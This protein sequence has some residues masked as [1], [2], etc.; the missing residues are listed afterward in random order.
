MKLN[1]QTRLLNYQATDISYVWRNSISN[2]FLMGKR[3]NFVD[4]G[5][6]VM[7]T[8][9]TMEHKAAVLYWCL[10]TLFVLLAVKCNLVFAFSNILYILSYL[11][12]VPDNNSRII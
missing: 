1:S 7:L 4:V 9:V 12:S 6:L 10:N 2:A 3:A 8:M 11:H 5:V